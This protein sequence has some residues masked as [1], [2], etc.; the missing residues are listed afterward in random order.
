MESL[1]GD[2]FC[3]WLHSY[4]MDV[5]SC[6]VKVLL[7]G[8]ILYR[9]RLLTASLSHCLHSFITIPGGSSLV[10]LLICI[11]LNWLMN[12]QLF[13]EV[14]WFDRQRRRAISTT[15]RELHRLLFLQGGCSYGYLPGI[16]E[17]SRFLTDF[18]WLND[19]RYRDH[20][21]ECWFFT[22]IVVGMLLTFEWKH[23]RVR[24]PCA[25]GEP[26]FNGE[27]VNNRCILRICY[28]R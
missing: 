11:Q 27:M 13:V 23:T 10:G 1:L 9:L 26:M 7:Q 16:P 3:E 18:H 8:N 22:Y 14:D 6:V 19:E 28:V 4:G 17:A 12:S 25:A 24:Y 15:T 20:L 2:F 21:C 5:V